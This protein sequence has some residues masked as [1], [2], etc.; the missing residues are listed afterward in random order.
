MLQG[1]IAPGDGAQRPQAHFRNG[2]FAERVL[3]PMENAVRIGPLDSLDPAH[4]C[5][6]NT[7]LVPYGGLLAAGLQPGQ[8]VLISGA[9]GHFES[10]G[11][12]VALAMGAACV[13]AAGREDDRLKDLARRFG[14]RVRTVQ[15]GGREQEDTRAMGEA[16]PGPVDVVF[17]QLP[18]LKD[19]TPVRAAAMAV[20]PHG[21]IVLMGGV[22]ADLALPYGHLMRNC[23]RYAA[24]TCIHAMRPNACWA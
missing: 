22:Q 6:L 20:R 2:A 11:V 5:A 1:L 15:L 10:A 24:S 4:V 13:I 19:A 3:I 18:P 7:L 12:A 8:T 14:P 9:T 17:D 21:T 23:I 16:A